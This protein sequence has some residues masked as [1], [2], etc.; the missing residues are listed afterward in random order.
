MSAGL[1]LVKRRAI[2]CP[3]NF[4]GFRFVRFWD[5]FLVVFAKLDFATMLPTK[6]NSFRIHD[7]QFARNETRILKFQLGNLA[8]PA[9]RAKVRPPRD[10]SRRD[11]I[12]SSNFHRLNFLLVLHDSDDFVKMTGIMS[13][14]LAFQI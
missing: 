12:I 11:E 10:R 4:L 13:D 8:L 6:H 5:E 2:Y 14:P 1:A 3:G 9:H 7:D